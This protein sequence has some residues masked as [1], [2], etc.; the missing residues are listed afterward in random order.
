MIFA[1]RNQ[2][3][4]RYLLCSQLTESEQYNVFFDS[5]SI[6]SLFLSLSLSIFAS[7]TI[8]LIVLCFQD[9][10]VSER[11]K[12]RAANSD[13]E[14]DRLDPDIF[15]SSEDDDDDDDDQGGRKQP[16]KVIPC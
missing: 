6:L 14:D 8:S 10:D 13:D 12:R 5:V 7:V 16:G 15:G 3:V 2:K 4:G 11:R 9:E 1:V